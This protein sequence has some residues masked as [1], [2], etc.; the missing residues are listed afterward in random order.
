[1][2]VGRRLGVTPD[3]RAA[4]IIGLLDRLGLAVGAP[5]VTAAAVA[6]HLEGDKKVAEGRLR[7]VLPTADGVVVRDDVPADAVEAGIAAALAG[8]PPQ[9]AAA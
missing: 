7:W 3:E 2:A 5:G 6:A 8:G 1:V 4:R 9:R